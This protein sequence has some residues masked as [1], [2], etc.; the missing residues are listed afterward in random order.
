[1]CKTTTM[2]TVL[3]MSATATLYSSPVRAQRTSSPTARSAP[4]TRS[5]RTAR[6]APTARRPTSGRQS[7]SGG[8]SSF[9][10]GSYFGTGGRRLPQSGSFSN[11]RTPARRPTVSPYL[12]LLGGNGRSTAFNYFRSVRPENEFRAADQGLNRSVQRLQGQITEQQ[13][14]LQNQ[15][16]GLTSSGHRTSFLNLGTYFPQTGR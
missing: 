9:G 15:A 4:T 7:S 8:R 3:L 2:L 12:N 14:L 11:L 6:S 1:M 13:R 5:A 16:S 10:A